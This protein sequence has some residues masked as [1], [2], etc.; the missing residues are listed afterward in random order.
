MRHVHRMGEDNDTQ[1]L[2]VPKVD[3]REFVASLEE[4]LRDL[5]ILRDA[6]FNGS[7]DEMKKRVSP[8][9]CEQVDRLVAYEAQHHVNL[10]PY[11]RAVPF[12]Q[13]A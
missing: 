11:V 8:S 13:G 10:G 5:V 6:R 4:T 3:H 7:W 9:V 2:Y 12:R 1:H